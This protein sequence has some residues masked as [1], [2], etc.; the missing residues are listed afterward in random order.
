MAHLD[1]AGVSADGRRL[2]LMD[3]Q[4]EEHTLEITP[5]LRS[6]LRGGT[7]RSP[8]LETQMTSTLR[9]REIQTRIRAGETP[10]AVATAAATT[11]DAIMPFVAPVLAEREHIAER[12]KKSSLRRPLGESGGGTRVLGDAVATHLA[13]HQAKLEVVSWDAFR[14][15]DGRWE[16]AGTFDTAPRSGVARFTFDPPGNYIVA[17]ND[18]ARW[19]VGDLVL[20]SEPHRDDLQQVRERRLAAVPADELPLG[21]D[22][23]DLVTGD[24]EL[25]GVDGDGSLDEMLIDVPPQRP[26]HD[27]P[28]RDT[29]A[30]LAPQPAH[31]DEGDASKH[32]RPVAKKRGRASVP[33]WDEIMF[34]GSAD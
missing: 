34:G 8:V 29:T 26:V 19:L 30:D 27:D 11:V 25:P 2:L 16:I 3:Q 17:D 12:A 13:D 18:D 24:V 14:R 31:D 23:L 1:L 7:T 15:D 20:H 28:L 32:R 33:S 10:E 4:G 22:A 5:A 9:P 21:D 6:A